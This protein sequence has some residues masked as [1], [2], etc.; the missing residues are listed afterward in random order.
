MICRIQWSVE[1]RILERRR[2][3]V[4][5]GQTLCA[6]AEAFGVPATLLAFENSLL[7][8]V[9]A[10]QV[11]HIPPASHLYTVRGGESRTLLCG[12]EENFFRKNGTR[13]LF[14]GQTVAL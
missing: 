11:L 2:Y 5:R 12:S 9:E 6:V 4:K 10:G 7:G 8:E 3:A 14:I 1:L 13:S